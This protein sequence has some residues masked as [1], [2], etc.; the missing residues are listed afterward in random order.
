MDN[1]EKKF[2]AIDLFSGIGGWSLGLRMAGIEVINSYEWW[3]KANTTN[4]KNNQHNATEIDIRQLKLEDL[5]K[6]ID[7]VVGSPPC[8]QFSFANRGGSGDIADGL[9]D[10][11]KFLSVVDYIRPKYWAMENIP[12]VAS[13]IENE[14]QEGGKLQQFAHLKPTIKTIDMSFWGLPQRRKRCIVGNFD[15]A[16]LNDYKE[17]TVSR[18][19]GDVITSLSKE[20]VNDPIY[21]VDLSRDKLIDHV[22]E[23]FLSPEEERMNREMK[24]YHPVYND[25][26]FPDP[27]DRTARTITA[28]CTRVSRESVVIASPESK[29]RFRRLTVRERGCIQGF[30][31]TYQFFGDSYAQKLKMIGNAVP[32]LFTFYVAQSMLGIEPKNLISPSK[33]IEVFLQSEDISPNTKPDSAGKSYQSTRKFRAAIPY[34]RFKSGVRFEFVNSFDQNIPDWKVRFYYGNSKNIMEFPLNESL[35]QQLKRVKPLK[36]IHQS[37]LLSISRAE[38]VITS[39]DAATLQDVWTRSKDDKIHPYDVVD[40]IGQATEDVINI[41]MEFENMS[42]QIV[43]DILSENLIT[44]GADK[45]IKHSNAALAGFLVGTSVNNLFEKSSFNKNIFN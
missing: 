30:P 39:T 6:D 13:I 37:V 43:K 2:R 11:A 41:L 17:K 18:T 20:I 7:I 40:I 24:A 31:I 3:D 26:S 35:L 9:K 10:I 45:I 33:G 5:P 44:V 15:F 19:L 29:G 23:E 22:A 42:T 25:M 12:R 4:F 32:P 8:T 16:L 36:S 28:T 21:G 34:L 38:Q 14:L 27:L 1:S